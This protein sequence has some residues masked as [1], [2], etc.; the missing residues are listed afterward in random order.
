MASRILNYYTVYCVQDLYRI[1][2]LEILTVFNLKYFS[3]TQL[4]LNICFSIMPVARALWQKDQV[5]S[6]ASQGR[7][8]PSSFN[9]FSSR[10]ENASEK[11]SPVYKKPKQQSL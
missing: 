11:S 1:I 6:E 7:R 9:E 10:S 4:N 8:Q 3:Q 5:Q 2:L